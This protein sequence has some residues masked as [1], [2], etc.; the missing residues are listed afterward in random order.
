MAARMGRS[1]THT[2]KSWFLR[3]DAAPPILLGILQTRAHW[4]ALDESFL[5]SRRSLDSK[6]GWLCGSQA[7]INATHTPKSWL[8]GFDDA[9]QILHCS[10]SE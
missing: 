7:W 9:A 4:K 2:P 10:F 5:L 8:L 1:K 3:F 6:Q